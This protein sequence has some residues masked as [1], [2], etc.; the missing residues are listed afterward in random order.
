M[1][2][3]SSL[4]ISVKT[5]EYTRGR[6]WAHIS[7][8]ITFVSKALWYMT[9]KKNGLLSDFKTSLNALNHS[10]FIFL[11]KWYYDLHRHTNEMTPLQKLNKKKLIILYLVKSLRDIWRGNGY[12]LKIF[13]SG[14]SIFF[15]ISSIYKGVFLSFE[16]MG[17]GG[18]LYILICNQY[19]PPVYPIC[20][21][22]FIFY[23]VFFVCSW[24]SITKLNNKINKTIA[25]QYAQIFSKH[26]I[27]VWQ[28]ITD[29]LKT[30]FYLDYS[31]ICA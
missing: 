22:H 1:S 21:D 8:I 9:V 4:Y 16:L 24:R 19:L 25:L 12:I 14:K 11:K 2:V 17:P 5:A 28:I 29:I 13:K 3:K 26:A 10:L 20:R 23:R 27:I 31:C 15:L 18:W 7:C 6:R 30:V